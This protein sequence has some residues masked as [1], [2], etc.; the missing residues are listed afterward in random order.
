MLLGVN[1]KRILIMPEFSLGF[2]HFVFPINVLVT[3]IYGL[4]SLLYS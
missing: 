4:S 2:F 3:K 1:A